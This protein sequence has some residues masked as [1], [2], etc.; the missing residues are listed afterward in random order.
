MYVPSY[1]PPKDD[2]AAKEVKLIKRM[3]REQKAKEYINTC[4]KEKERIV[5]WVSPGLMEDIGDEIRWWFR[6][7]YDVA[8]AFDKYPAKEKGGTSNYHFLFKQFQFK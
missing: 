5:K 4:L 6:N 1:S 3:K 7:W 8:K 2:N